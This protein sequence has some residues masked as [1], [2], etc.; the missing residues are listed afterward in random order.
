MSRRKILEKLRRAVE[1]ME[2]S[3]AEKAA[4]E[5][6]AG[7]IDPIVAI[8]EGLAVGMKTV[9]DLFDEGEVFVPHLLV[10]A[11][12]FETGVAILTESMPP[13]ARTQS[14]QGKVLIHTVQGDIHDIGKNIVKTMLSASGFEVFDLGR[15]VPVAAVVTKAQE[16]QVDIIVGAALM[17]TTMPAQREL[18][19]CLQEEGIRQQFK[20]IFGGAPVSSEWVKRIG[21]DGYAESASAA[22]EVA[23]V[24]MAEKRAKG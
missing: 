3:L 18:I 1:E 2:T 7:G 14:S 13:E 8:N 17:T 23:R 22:I 24:L 21:A 9:S 6:V 12:A 11:E 20:I 5:A 4:K 10:A 19:K 16:L 15:D